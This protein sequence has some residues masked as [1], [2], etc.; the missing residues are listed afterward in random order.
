MTHLLK[1]KTKIVLKKGFWSQYIKT[2]KINRYFHPFKM[3]KTFFSPDERFCR[4]KQEGTLKNS[5]LESQPIIDSS[6]QFYY[7]HI[8][9]NI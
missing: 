4:E 1:I 7:K 8:P 2:Y 6:K 5:L 3:I 9:I